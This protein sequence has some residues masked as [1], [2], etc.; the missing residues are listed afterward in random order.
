V[1]PEGLALADNLK[2]EI[3][4][5]RR[6]GLFLSDWYLPQHPGIAAHG[7]D[8]VAH[9]CQAGWRAGVRP[10]PYFD[11]AWYLSRNPEIAAA[12]V[13]PLLHYIA[14]GEAEGRD[15]CPWFDVRWYRASYGLGEKEPCLTHYLERRMTGQVNP[16]P[17]FDAAYYLEN[18]PDV[19]VP[20]R[21]SIS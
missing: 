5:I 4:V 16:V 7:E 14:F 20:I 21:S 9:F 11:P 3:A 13:N 15:P 8:G 1:T 12:G 19:A 10:N 2:T 18:N 17:V 6:S